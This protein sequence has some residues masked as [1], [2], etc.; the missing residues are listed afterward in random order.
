MGKATYITYV[1]VLRANGNTVDGEH[2]PFIRG[3]WN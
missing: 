1:K 2:S 3:L